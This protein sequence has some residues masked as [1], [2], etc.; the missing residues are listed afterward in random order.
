MSRRLEKELATLK[1]ALASG[2]FARARKL[3]ASTE[4]GKPRRARPAP[5]PISL[6]EAVKPLAGKRSEQG[7]WV[8]R[9]EPDDAEGMVSAAQRQYALVMRGARQRL[10]ELGASPAL[11]CAASADP[12]DLLFVAAEAD[13][14]AAEAAALLIG[15]M[16]YESDRLVFE[17]YL[18]V[19]DRQQ[20]D[21]CRLFAERYARCGLVVTFSTARSQIK[22]LGECCAA[23]GVDLSAEAWQVPAIRLRAAGV[24]HLDLRKECRRRWG[25]SGRRCTPAALERSLLRRGRPGLMRRGSVTEAFQ[26]F[27]VTGDAANI[28]DILRHNA[29][30]LLTMSQL[31]CLLL[32]GCDSLAGDEC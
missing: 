23:A 12:E 20:R 13:R 11:C 19:E 1:R 6:I 2:D 31:L 16:F 30:D 21:V 17:Q 15:V 7:A 18:G 27:A 4:K 26:R 22:L 28:P 32:T 25:G 14:G 8:V 9:C 3:M 5:S 29:L 10:E 24:R